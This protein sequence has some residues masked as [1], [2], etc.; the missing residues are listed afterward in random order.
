MWKH[1]KLEKSYFFLNST[2][3]NKIEITGDSA[4]R[5]QNNKTK[6]MAITIKEQSESA[7]S[8]RQQ[9]PG[10]AESFHKTEAKQCDAFKSRAK[11]LSLFRFFLCFFVIFFFVYF[12]LS[13]SII[14]FTIVMYIIPNTKYIFNIMI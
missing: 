11:N 14:P 8:Q 9:S 13:Y 12:I 10:K 5:E 6:Q 2:N 3:N 7:Q 4:W 1:W